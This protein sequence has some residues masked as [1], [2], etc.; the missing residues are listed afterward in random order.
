MLDVTVAQADL[1]FALNTVSKAINT[2]NT[3]PVLNNILIEVK[4]GNL[5]F[6]GTNLEIAIKT[7]IKAEVK[8]EGSIT[9]P[10]KLLTSYVQL[11]N[12]KSVS[13]ST[14]RDL[15]LEV[16][17]DNDYTKI[18][19]IKADDFPSIPQI[20]AEFEITLPA[21]QLISALQSTSFAASLHSS[22]P[23]LAGVF[24]NFT[25]N[26]LVFAATD[27]YRL[28]EYRLNLKDKAK[29]AQL[30]IPV[31]TAIELTKI[32]SAEPKSQVTI[33]A[34]KNQAEFQ[35]ADTTVVTRLIE[36]VFPDY[37]KIIPKES[38]TEAIVSTQ[39]LSLAI[40]KIS[41]FAREINNN[42]RI[43]VDANSITLSTEETKVGEGEITIPA[44]VNG[45][46]NQIAVNAQYLLDVIANSSA[47]ETAIDINE[48]LSPLVIQPNK[49]INYLYLIMPLKA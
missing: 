15:A 42:M 36:G 39:D 8:A 31:R 46:A 11:L 26:E 6:S 18:K 19:G 47:K 45:E 41:L 23:V 34:T 40:K 27:S 1:N 9:I 28:A 44:K 32:I 48:K 35:F 14:T 37:N 2:T 5:H 30:I 3:L 43:S 16:N 22:R 4:E 10:A 7:K 24:L 21:S 20:N 12:T 13:L 33:K 49:E 25:E 17:T 29:P 38:K